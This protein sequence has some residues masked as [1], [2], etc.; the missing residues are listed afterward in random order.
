MEYLEKLA[1]KHEQA[2]AT[3]QATEKAAEQPVETVEEPTDAARRFGQLVVKGAELGFRFI[4]D[5]VKYT[6]STYDEAAEKLGPLAQKYNI[7]GPER[8]PYEQEIEGGLFLGRLWRKT[9]ARIHALRDQDK[10]QKAQSN[11]DQR[12]YQPAES[13][14][15]V[16]GEERPRQE[17]SPYTS[18]W[19]S[20]N[21]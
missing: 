19:D 14:H 7:S 3:E 18:Q 15:P 21:G 11:G 1:A 20:A 16:S 6:E 4:D 9:W 17:S 5:R 10:K 8:F 2:E 13:A 12:E